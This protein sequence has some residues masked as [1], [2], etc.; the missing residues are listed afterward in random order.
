MFVTSKVIFRT[1][2][3]NIPTALILL[4]DFLPPTVSVPYVGDLHW[5]GDEEV[6]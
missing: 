4:I 5:N 1:N 3:F 2:T 6:Y